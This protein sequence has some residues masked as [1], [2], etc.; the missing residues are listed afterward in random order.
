LGPVPSLPVKRTGTSTLG[1]AAVPHLPVSQFPESPCSTGVPLL[2]F[3]PSPLLPV[4]DWGSSSCPSQGFLCAPP[5]ISCPS[6]RANA[7]GAAFLALS[8]P[9]S[10]P[11]PSNNT[12]TAGPHPCPFLPRHT[13]ALA[14][15][16]FSGVA[17]HTLPVRAVAVDSASSL[18]PSPCVAGDCTLALVPA[19]EMHLVPPLDLFRPLPAPCTAVQHLGPSLAAHLRLAAS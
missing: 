15:V 7:P 14:Q 4:L 16:G 3:P 12:V 1:G 11:P 19:N 6:P 2:C 13:S 8:S 5:S 10:S 18:H 17:P 9:I